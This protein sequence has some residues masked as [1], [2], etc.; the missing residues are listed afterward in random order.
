MLRLLVRVKRRRRV[1]A[2]AID[3]TAWPR[4]ALEPSMFLA[5]ERRL[6]AQYWRP[7]LAA[8]HRLEAFGGRRSPHRRKVDSIKK[9]MIVSTCR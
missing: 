8:H 5:F 1:A 6:I 7:Q 9:S 3:S 2:N 4:R